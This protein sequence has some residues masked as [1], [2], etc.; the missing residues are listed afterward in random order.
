MKCET[1]KLTADLRAE[2]D[3]AVIPRMA[4][5]PLADAVLREYYSRVSDV[6]LAE[7][8]SKRFFKVGRTAVSHRA[9]ALG[10]PR[11]AQ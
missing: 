5:T 8:L 7:I 4:W 9:R 2:L 11:R 3:A 10:I 1:V 6:R